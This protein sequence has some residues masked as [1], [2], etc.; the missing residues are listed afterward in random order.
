MQPC[1]WMG[2]ISGSVVI[3]DMA[4]EDIRQDEGTGTVSNDQ[5]IDSLSHEL[6]MLKAMLVE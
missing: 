1:V 3:R 4:M 2:A 6:C 5:G